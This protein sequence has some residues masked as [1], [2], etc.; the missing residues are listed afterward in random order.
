MC[1]KLK[2]LKIQYSLDFETFKEFTFLC[3]ISEH[4]NEFRFYR[5]RGF[6]RL[7]YDFEVPEKAELKN[8]TAWGRDRYSDKFRDSFVKMGKK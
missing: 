5:S 2:E 8:W 4:L 3:S 6:T 1:K 7:D